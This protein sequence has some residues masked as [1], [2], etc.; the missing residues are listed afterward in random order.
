MANPL[1]SKKS[2][3]KSAQAKVTDIKLDEALTPW[4]V[5][6]IDDEDDVISISEMVL[7]RVLVDSRPLEFLKAHSA[8]EAKDLFEQHSDI[9]IALVDVVM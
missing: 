7:K 4:K 3:P 2:V 9:A 6:L 5:A 1:F 8:Q